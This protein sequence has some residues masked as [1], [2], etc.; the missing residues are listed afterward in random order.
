M[1]LNNANAMVVHIWHGRTMKVL[2]WV[3]ETEDCKV[4]QRLVHAIN[5]D[6]TMSIWG[7]NVRNLVNV[8][9]RDILAMGLAM[10]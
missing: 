3:G 1:G 5:R 9:C 6:L 7:H 8:L 10:N 2:S 4:I